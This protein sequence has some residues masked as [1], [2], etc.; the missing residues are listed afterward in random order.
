VPSLTRGFITGTNPYG[1]TPNFETSSPEATSVAIFV[2]TVAEGWKLCSR[3]HLTARH[4]VTSSPTSPVSFERRGFN[5]YGVFVCG[6]LETVRL[7]S[8]QALQ[9][10]ARP[11]TDS[12]RSLKTDR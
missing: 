4:D 1:V 3:I 12:L 8:L 2:I 9:P 10:S 11:V 5:P 6:V 7:R